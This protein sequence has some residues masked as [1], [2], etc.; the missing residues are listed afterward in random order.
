MTWKTVLGGVC[1]T[2]GYTRTEWAGLGEK[3]WS[4]GT[5]WRLG[6]PLGCTGHLQRGAAS[7]LVR[8]MVNRRPQSH[9]FI[10]SITQVGKS[11]F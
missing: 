7:R 5:G 8:L 6:C 1:F 4:A 9:G 10:I 2:L 11:R 3:A